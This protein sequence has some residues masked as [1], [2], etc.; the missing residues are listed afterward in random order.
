MGVKV[1]LLL[2]MVENKASPPLLVM[3]GSAA[4]R[5]IKKNRGVKVPPLLAKLHCP[6]MAK[7]TKKKKKKKE[8]VHAY[9]RIV[10]TAPA[11]SNSHVQ[12]LSSRGL[13]LLKLMLQALYDT[14]PSSLID[15]TTNPKV[16]TTKG[17]GVRARSLARCTSRVEGCARAP[18]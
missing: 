16:K 17:K 13:L 5:S 3:V 4:P 14:P 8:W 1:P 9:L 18:R 7:T 2:V 11:T 15:S 6:P 12:G 10:N